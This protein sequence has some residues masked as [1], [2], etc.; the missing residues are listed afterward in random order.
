METLEIGKFK[1]KTYSEVFEKHKWYCDWVI[2]QNCEGQLVSFKNY[3]LK[4]I[5]P[6]DE[7]N[8]VN[9]IPT[10]KD[11]I[12]YNQKCLKCG[13]SLRPLGDKR[14]N[15]QVGL[16]DWETRKYHRKCFLEFA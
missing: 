13:Q 4:Q 5:Q 16:K 11:I 12:V 10:K 3:I 9:I 1:N 8:N 2:K 15:G 7:N 14:K 6:K